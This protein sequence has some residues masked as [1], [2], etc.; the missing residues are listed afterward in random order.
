MRKNNEI[1]QPHT[2]TPRYGSTESHSEAIHGI[3]MQT[4]TGL[5]CTT[6]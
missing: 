1:L 2:K 5:A 4:P 6:L 3:P